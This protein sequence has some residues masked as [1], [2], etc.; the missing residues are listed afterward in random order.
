M[1]LLFSAS[2]PLDSQKGENYICKMGVFCIRV[3]TGCSLYA[4]SIDKVHLWL[5]GEHGEASLG[6]LP[7][8]Q[9]NSVSF[10]ELRLGWRGRGVEEWG[11]G[12][13]RGRARPEKSQG[14]LCWFLS[15]TEGSHS[16]G[17]QSAC[18]EALRERSVAVGGNSP[19]RPSFHRTPQDNYQ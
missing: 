1:A 13:G 8:P 4:G 3:S 5:V 6:M 10:T 9:R 14:A 11:I 19:V 16:P 17:K 18:R 15:S 7:A 2:T 12:G